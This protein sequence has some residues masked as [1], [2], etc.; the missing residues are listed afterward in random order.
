MFSEEKKKCEIFPVYT[1]L[2]MVFKA[3][4]AA[5]MILTVNLAGKVQGMPVP[6]AI[7]MAQEAAS[8]LGVLESCGSACS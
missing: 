2:S 7:S 1:H 3:K 6:V 5:C 8:R 4:V